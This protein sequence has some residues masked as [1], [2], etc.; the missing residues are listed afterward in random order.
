[1][2][3]ISTI[4]Y[5]IHIITIISG[6]IDPGNYMSVTYNEEGAKVY[7][8]QICQKAFKRSSIVKTHIKTVHH[9]ERQVQC[10]ICAKLFKN[11]GSLTTHFKI[12]HGLAKDQ[13]H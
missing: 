12:M 9:S 3:C 8:C 2:K 1:M 4:Q 11:S 10:G 7:S 13:V 5:V 6:A